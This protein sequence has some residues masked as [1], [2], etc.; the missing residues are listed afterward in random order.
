MDGGV[1]NRVLRKNPV[2]RRFFL[3]TF[4]ADQIPAVTEFPSSMVVNMDNSDLPG[5]HWVAMYVP[6]SQTV[7][8]Y[9]S[10]GVLPSNKNIR[11]FLAKFK[12]M[13]VNSVTFQSVISDVCGYYV[14]YF[15]YFCSLGYDTRRITKELASHDNP[16]I[17]V[18]RF[19]NRHIIV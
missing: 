4:P 6:D 19:T 18:W 13:E 17:H 11:K 10:F 14:M 8:Y 16:D 9:D 2:T 15:L 12:K 5:S 1:I 7:F 3:D